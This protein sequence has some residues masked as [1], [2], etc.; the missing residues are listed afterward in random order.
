MKN[1][2]T[3]LVSIFAF[4]VL[5][6]ALAV[7]QRDTLPV[8]RCATTEADSIRFLR[9][10]Q[11]LNIRQRSEQIIQEYLQEKRSNL[12]KSGSE[13]LTIPVV[14]HVIHNSPNAGNSEGDGKP[15]NPNITNQQIASQIDVLNEDY[16]N[17]SGYKG[18][19]TDSLAVDTK[20]QFKLAGT[21]RTY[22][23]VTEFNPIFDDVKLAGISPPWPTDRYLNIWVCTLSSRYLGAAQFPVVTKDTI[24]TQGLDLVT[25]DDNAQ[26]DGVIIDYRYFGRNV[27]AITSGLYNLGR[28]TTHEVGHWLGLLHTWGDKYCGTDY[29]DDTPTAA[30]ANEVTDLNCTPVFSNCRGVTTR[31][32]IENY[33]DYSPDRCM[34]VFTQDQADRMGV[35]LELSPRRKKMVENSRRTGTTV[36]VNIYPNPTSDYVRADIY[37]PDFQPFTLDLF[38]MS[39]VRLQG[40]ILNQSE[41]NVM[42]YPS[43]LYLLRVTTPTESV[44]KR[45]I[46]R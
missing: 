32:M 4:I 43:G 28:T 33:M 39:G 19:Y 10:P 46:I 37:T 3:D 24:G 17:Q 41:I 20:V 5:N 34:S 9:N 40:D 11:L 18:F 35:V 13:V 21:V 23:D 8:K 44:T 14:V 2:K 6:T 15:G 26:T 16:S 31:N 29:C 7:A 36:L 22:S 27:P 12:R 25:E 45:F 1:R 42:N 30:Y 38:N